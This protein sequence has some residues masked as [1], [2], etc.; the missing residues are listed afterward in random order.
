M[1]KLIVLLLLITNVCFA[2]I[3]KTKKQM[4]EELSLKFSDTYICDGKFD[5]TGQD[6]IGICESNVGS[7]SLCYIFEK[8]ICVEFNVRTDSEEASVIIANLNKNKKLIR[9][10]N[11]WVNEKE[12]IEWSI[13]DLPAQHIQVTCKKTK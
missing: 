6:W 12:H 2:Q 3:G 4:R 8:G 9:R 5:N 10:G 1:R 13:K 7:I 11:K